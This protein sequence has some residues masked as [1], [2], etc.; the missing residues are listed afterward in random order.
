MLQNHLQDCILLISQLPTNSLFKKSSNYNK[1]K[2][3]VM[4]KLLQVSLFFI[5]FL[6]NF[7]V[8]FAETVFDECT[9]VLTNVPADIT[10]ECDNVPNAP[11][12]VEAICE[13][14]TVL[15]KLEETIDFNS[16]DDSY[17]IKRVWTATSQTGNSAVKTQLIT[18]EDNTPPVLS[19]VPADLITECDA[20]PVP[21][22]NI[23]ATDDCDS[24]VDIVFVEFETPGACSGSYVLTRSWTATDNCGNSAVETQLITVDD[25]T[26]PLFQG[27]PDD[28][29]LSC[30]DT[31]P[32]PQ[33]VT[34]TD[35]CFPNLPLPKFVQTETGQCPNKIITRTWTSTDDCGNVAVYE[36]IITLEGEGNLKYH[37]RNQA[38]V[39]FFVANHPTS[40]II[41]ELIIGEKTDLHSNIDITDISGLLSIK[42]ITGDLIV[43]YTDKLVDIKGLNNIKT[44]GGDVIF[45][46]NKKLVVNDGF[47]NL[48]SIGGDLKISFDVINGFNSLLSIGKD[49][50]INS[51]SSIENS[52]VNGFSILK[53]IG[54]NF[55]FGNLLSNQSGSFPF[56]LNGLSKLYVVSG[57]LTMNTT[58]IDV[59]PF[60]DLTTIGGKLTIKNCMLTSLNGLN[61]LVSTKHL[62]IEYNENLTN[63][64]ALCTLFDA[65]GVSGII[66]FNH[67]PSTCSSQ[68]AIESECEDPDGF[69]LRTQ[70]Q[71]DDFI[72]NY[73]TK[74][75]IS[76]DLIIGDNEAPFTTSDITNIS[77][78]SFIKTLIG[79]L[80]IGFNN[81]LENLNGLENLT[82][83][84]GN[85]TIQNNEILNKFRNNESITT[86]FENISQIGGD[87]Q[88]LENN[89]LASL[90]GLENLSTVGGKLV[91]STNPNLSNCKGICN[92]LEND[93]VQGS[94]IIIGNP[95]GCS[96]QADVDQSCMVGSS[97][98][99]D[100]NQILLSPNP[101]ENTLNVSSIDNLTISEI[102]I[103]DQFGKK[104]IHTSKSQ[105]DVTML[106][107]GIYFVKVKI[108]NQFAFRK[109]L[110]F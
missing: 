13:G 54:G 3:L 96:N 59:L 51:Y 95:S 2:I 4:R 105:I 53:T 31:L 90:N 19:N 63:C 82:A 80:Y 48:Q 27:V 5:L 102:I 30:S 6:L 14:E 25:T 77:G 28:I 97:D 32:K 81:S 79:N 108:G 99:L 23:Y 107:D 94:I 1:R 89:A 18:V 76:G 64:S 10:V 38:D 103:L 70:A 66:E 65:D 72:A 12:D 41:H 43:G 69:M 86:G 37:L 15:P 29:T 35:N 60:N 45:I 46:Q 49:L 74:T 47:L 33:N 21:P 104:L 100:A 67:N 36:Q 52:V 50:I 106:T 11:S 22:N 73:S 93:G 71:V 98:L 91:I 16:C 75:T 109:F 78:L 39:D 9:P 68:S 85:V 88:I 84:S 17:T 101:T 56:S 26:A 24:D 57:D 92:I 110:K 20:V 58:K 55:E 7:S 87:L 83:I 44:I 42:S 8:S 40:G 34:S 62:V 61:N